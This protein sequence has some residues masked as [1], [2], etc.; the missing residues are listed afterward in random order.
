MSNSKTSKAT[1]VSK[2][3]QPPQISLASQ[4][5]D[6]D[7]KINKLER[8]LQIEYSFEKEEYIK[9]LY[10]DRRKLKELKAEQDDI[11]TKDEIKQIKIKIKDLEDKNPS[12]VYYQK[13]RDEIERLYMLLNKEKFNKFKKNENNGKIIETK[14]QRELYNKYHK[15]CAD[16]YKVDRTSPERKEIEDELDTI[17]DKL[18]FQKSI[19]VENKE[20]KVFHYSQ[21]HSYRNYRCIVIDETANFYKI[22]PIEKKFMGLD[23]HQSSLYTYIY[24][25]IIRDDLITKYSKTRYFT[26][27]KY[28]EKEDEYELCD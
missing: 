20:Y 13:D 1:K 27:V 9:E 3:T 28:Y 7:D 10:S 14:E 2:Q 4:I 16:Q 6:L 19:F 24:P 23:D 11:L 5:N 25:I 8:Q 26:P 15:L 21:K 22:L 12:Y 17:K 18:S